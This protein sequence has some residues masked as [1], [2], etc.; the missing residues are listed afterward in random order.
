MQSPVSASSGKTRAGFTLIELLVVLAII[1]VLVAILMPVI[2]RVQNTARKVQAVNDMHN[3]KVS[4]ISFYQDYQKYPLNDVQISAAEPDNGGNDT[5]YGDVPGK[6]TSAELFD[7]LRA[8]EDATQNQG[9]KL[10]PGKVVYWTGPFA[11]NPTTPRNG[12]TTQ[13]VMDGVNEIPVG[14]LVDP[15]GNPYVVW[16]D[17]NKDGDLSTAFGWFYHDIVAGSIRP[18]TAPAGVAFASL[19]PDGEWGTRDDGILA[20]SDD[21]VIYQ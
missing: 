10:N 16:F 15:W 18:G 13:K 6:Y 8:V 11:K 3:V 12:I 9:N 14:S 17:A 21:I 1:A 20:N 4:I 7:V 19:G 2:T 5:V